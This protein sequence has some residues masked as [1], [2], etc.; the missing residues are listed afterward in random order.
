MA[1]FKEKGSDNP[2]T[3]VDPGDGSGASPGHSDI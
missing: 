2:E 1:C 3:P